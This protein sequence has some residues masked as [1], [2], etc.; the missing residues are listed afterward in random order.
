LKAAA[1]CRSGRAA[2]GTTP[3][4][5]PR[6]LHHPNADARGQRRGTARRPSAKP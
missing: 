2:G 5:L 6:S 4:P 3:K 1:T